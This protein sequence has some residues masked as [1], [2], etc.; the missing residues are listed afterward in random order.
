MTVIRNGKIRFFAQSDV[1]CY[2][3]RGRQGDL[4]IDT[5]LPQTFRAMRPISGWTTETRICCAGLGLMRISFRCRGIHTARS[6]Y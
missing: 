3:L 6:A 4:L 2:I 5:G 1:T